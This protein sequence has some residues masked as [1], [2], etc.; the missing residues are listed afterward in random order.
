MVIRVS[1]GGGRREADRV[2]WGEVGLLVY[3]RGDGSDVGIRECLSGEMEG[4]GRGTGPDRQESR[5]GAEM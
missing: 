2:R 1:G 4:R 5:R 3:F